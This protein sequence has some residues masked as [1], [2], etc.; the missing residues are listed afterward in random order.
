MRTAHQIEREIHAAMTDA[1]RREWDSCT[2]EEKAAYR[3]VMHG[4]EMDVAEKGRPS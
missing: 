1:M 3:L 2:D 4:I